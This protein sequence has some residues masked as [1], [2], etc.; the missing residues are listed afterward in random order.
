MDIPLLIHECSRRGIKF[1]PGESGLQILAIPGEIDDGFRAIISAHKAA[2][3][4]HF[5]TQPAESSPHDPSFSPLSPPGETSGLSVNLS[6]TSNSIPFSPLSPLEKREESYVWENKNDGSE[7]REGRRE[8][9]R[10]YG[11]SPL[12]DGGLSGL[13]SHNLFTGNDVTSSPNG[14]NSGL[15]GGLN[16][17]TGGLNPFQ[18]DQAALRYPLSPTWDEL[19]ALR[20]VPA[21]DEDRP[22]VPAEDDEP[23]IVIDIP[24]R[25][26]MLAALRSRLDGGLA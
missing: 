9:V 16:G 5:A 10:V 13:N 3:V 20:W 6:S 4:A 26:R 12:C 15:I 17:L 7:D 2:I 1:E 11:D 21:M 19:S 18:T 22:W 14:E 25:G 23:G 24:D 8:Y